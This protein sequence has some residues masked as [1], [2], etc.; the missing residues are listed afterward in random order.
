MPYD[1][2]STGVDEVSGGRTPVE[3][4]VFVVIIVLFA[5]LIRAVVD[6]F[7]RRA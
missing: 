5:L 3:L 4:I 1:F 7:K 6:R 2:G